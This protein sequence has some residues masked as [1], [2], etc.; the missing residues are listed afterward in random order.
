MFKQQIESEYTS[1]K[2]E[3]VIQFNRSKKALLKG[4][5]INYFCEHLITASPI[6]RKAFIDIYREY[7]EAFSKYVIAN[8]ENEYD[9]KYTRFGGTYRNIIVQ[10]DINAL[11]VEIFMGWSDMSQTEVTKYIKSRIFEVENNWAAYKAHG[12]PCKPERVTSYRDKTI[13]MLDEIRESTGKKIVLLAVTDEKYLSILESEFGME[14]CSHIFPEIACKEIGFDGVWGAREF[15]YHV[16]DK[17]DN[18]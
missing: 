1:S 7:N 6:V 2:V 9:Y 5:D 11:P 18:D 13:T 15:I 16:E 4:K 8:T 3:N 14:Y 12:T 10:I 17:K